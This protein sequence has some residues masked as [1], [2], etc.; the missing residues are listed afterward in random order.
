MLEKKENAK[1]EVSLEKDSKVGYAFEEL[2][3]E[4]MSAIQGSGAAKA[5]SYTTPDC[6]P[7]RF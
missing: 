3:V 2:S 5:D 4:E 1:K 7:W 6:S